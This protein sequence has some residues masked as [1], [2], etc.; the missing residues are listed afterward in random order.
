R[1]NAIRPYDV[2][3]LGAVGGQDIVLLKPRDADASKPSILAAGG[4]HGEEPAGPWGIVEFLETAA[5]ATLKSVN[6]S[7]LPL[8][9]P[10]GFI[11]AQRLNIYGENPNRGF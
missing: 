7:F 6:Y 5:E 8:V 3:T 10:T 1:V 9:N 11:K 4:F 2:E